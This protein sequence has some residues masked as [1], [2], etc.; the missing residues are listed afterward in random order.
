MAAAGVAV[1]AFVVAVVVDV[2]VDSTVASVVGGLVVDVVL[3]A[4]SVDEFESSS[5]RKNFGLRLLLLLFEPVTVVVVV[6]G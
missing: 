4:D 3:G 1:A 5:P 6:A 2:V